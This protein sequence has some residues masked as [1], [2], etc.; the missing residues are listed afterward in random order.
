MLS[1]F[2]GMQPPNSRYGAGATPLGGPWV[3]SEDFKLSRRDSANQLPQTLISFSL[4]AENFPAAWSFRALLWATWRKS[5]HDS[6]KK[7]VGGKINAGALCH[8]SQ[9]LLIHPNSWKN[10]STSRNASKVH[11]SQQ[12]RTIC[13]LS[14]PCKIRNKEW[15]TFAKLLRLSVFRNRGIFS[16]AMYSCSFFSGDIQW[17]RYYSTWISSYSW[18]I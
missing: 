13:F 18:S 11:R 9:P 10:Y 7:K 3:S 15:K 5:T 8:P 12:Q 16:P 2:R 6:S 1:E 17:H 4:K 14:L